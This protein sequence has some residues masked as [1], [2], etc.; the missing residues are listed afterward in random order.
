MINSFTLLGSASGRNAGDAALMSAIMDSV[1]EA[2]GERLLYEIP[3]LNP[4][5]VW[6]T[7]QN[8]VRPIGI[9]PWNASLKLLGPPTYQ[10]LMR[11]DMSLVFDAI[12]FDRAL[13]NPFFNFLSSLYLLLPQARKKGKKMACY[14]VTVGPVKTPRGKEMLKRTLELMDFIS[15]RD[16]DSVDELREAGIENPNVIITNDVALNTKPASEKRIEEIWNSFGFEQGKEV[17]AVNVNPYFD[18]WA[19]LNRQPLS[20]EEFVR[21]Y[22]QAIT[23]AVKHEDLSLLFVSTQ[24]MDEVLTKEIMNRVNTV[25]RKAIFSNRV[26]N[27]HEIK[28]VMGKASLLFAMRLHCL[29][30]TSSAMTPIISLNYLPKVHTYM[31]SLGLNDYSLGFEDFSVDS[32]RDHLKKGWSNRHAIKQQLE[33]RIPGMQREA[34]KAAEL[35]ACMRRGEDISRALHRL[36]QQNDQPQIVSAG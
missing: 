10:S 6:R 11:T 19:G 34:S 29:I 28:G 4:E 13:Y 24:H 16:Q 17:L 21:N 1:D 7:Y 32:I 9:L 22:A 26:Y 25:H 33:A 31:K 12:L 18:T 3:S 5:F 20:R 36:S 8:R 15:V 35:V 14:T 23:E 30:L 27:H 2:T